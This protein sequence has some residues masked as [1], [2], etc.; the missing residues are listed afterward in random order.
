MMKFDNKKNANLISHY[1]KD[2]TTFE[3]ST[4]V[5]EEFSCYEAF[6]SELQ[7]V[8]PEQR[9]ATFAGLMS[10][11][12]LKA[13]IQHFLIKYDIGE[14][15]NPMAVPEALQ[16]AFDALILEISRE[17]LGASMSKEGKVVFN[18]KQFAEC[19]MKIYGLIVNRKDPDTLLVYDKT[20]GVWED[21]RI[22]LN[23]LIIEVAHYLGGNILDSWDGGL[24]KSLEA[25]LLRKAPII[26]PQHFNRGYFPFTNAT[27][28]T[29]NVKLVAH[30]ANYRATMGSPIIYQVEAACPTFESFLM[31]I[32]EDETTIQF[33]QE[34]F[35]YVLSDSH[36]ANALLIGVGAG[37]NGKSTLFDVLAKLVGVA[38]VSSAPLSNFN[39]DFGLEPLIGM[40]L[41]L[42]T[43]SDADAFK[44]GKLKA[45]TAGEAISVNRKNKQEVTIILPTKLVFL[46]NELPMLSDSSKGFERRLIIL[47]FNKTFTPS[48][49][50]KDLPKKLNAELSGILNWA[51]KGLER[52]V[53]NGYQFSASDAMKRAKD[54]YFGVGNPVQRFVKDC[55]VSKPA[56]TMESNSIL[57]AYQL[58][59]MSKGYPY[60][61][62]DSNQVFWR[63]FE[64]AAAK[65]LIE[66]KKSKSNGKMVVRDI[67]LRSE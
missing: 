22:S 3:D 5:V 39:S 4:I 49:Q 41:N 54:T 44:T 42:A 67:D 11:Y 66:F 40:K 30:S 31:D 28:D 65:E 8:R 25:I 35:G 37:A 57:H 47:P 33:V 53:E 60:K 24:E 12:E 51:L 26:D 2:Q 46:V 62:T 15:A 13:A 52:L 50:D 23:R 27:L 9:P 18:K 34:W 14:G 7:Q 16:Q 6:D 36:K 1:L 17:I 38:N 56:N 21:A 59:M 10:G 63:E 61:G 58:W 29:E 19:I 55:I 64:E 32:F 45:L 20:T 43:E 48:Q